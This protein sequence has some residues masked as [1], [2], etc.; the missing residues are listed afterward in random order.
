MSARRFRGSVFFSSTPLPLLSLTCFLFPEP[1]Q[2]PSLV[3]LSFLLFCSS[4]RLRFCRGFFFPF[5]SLLDVKQFL[6]LVKTLTVPCAAFCESVCFQAF[7]FP[8]PHLR[9]ALFRLSTSFLSF[10]HR[11]LL[12]DAF[13]P[14][15]L[16]AVDLFVKLQKDCWFNLRC[17]RPL[18]PFLVIV[19]S[20]FTFVS[21]CL[22]T[23]VVSG[24]PV[25]F[26]SVHVVAGLKAFFLE[27]VL[28]PP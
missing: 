14:P 21:Y 9:R 25:T 5:L 16:S 27:I 1:G 19:F 18:P 3:S 4:Y 15:L 7:F 6:L 11:R 12:R 23:P 20:N 24:L 26:T 8:S 13:F 28:V 10:M 22:F 2:T 17:F